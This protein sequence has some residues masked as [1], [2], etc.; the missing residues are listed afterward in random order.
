[1]VFMSEQWLLVTIL[2]VLVSGLI[3][4]E[5]KRGGDSLSFH[6]LTT[7]V[8]QGNAVVVDVRETKEFKTGHIVN[9]LNIPHLKLGDRL[10]ELNKHKE[11]TIIVVD[12]MGQHAGASGRLLKE[13]GF[14][15]NR[16]QGGMSEWQAQ[17]L[18]VIKS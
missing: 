3:V 16:L 5:G 7:L 11:K 4:V 12:K 8:N 15:V 6:Q 14:N 1:M 18:P 10:G 17:N 9:A 13:N 2:A